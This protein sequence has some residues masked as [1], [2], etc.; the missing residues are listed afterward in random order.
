MNAKTPGSDFDVADFV[1]A[2][3]RGCSVARF[4]KGAVIY[5]QGTAANAVY[6]LKGG[7]VKISV[8]SPQG[9]EGVLAILEAGSF[10]GEGCLH[11][12]KDRRAT[13]VAMAES[14]I[15]RVQK[16]DMLRLLDR[17]P[18]FGEAFRNYLLLRSERVEEDLVDQ[19]FNS[20]EQRL[21]RALLLLA[22]VEK[23]GKP[24]PITPPFSHET[25][26]EMIGTTRPRVSAFM[27]KFQKLGYISNKGGLRVHR[28]L[29]AV[30]SREGGQTP[31][32]TGFGPER[33]AGSLPRTPS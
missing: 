3:G 7:I 25:L 23:E 14:E 9:K 8:T 19:L 13:A 31:S 4:R 21:A 28:S 24:Q 29:F 22:P 17:E 10:F 33:R 16:E 12:E 11:G 6:Y 30:L 26:A 27:T 32:S 18:R 15:L 20:S 2:S 1:G 5:S